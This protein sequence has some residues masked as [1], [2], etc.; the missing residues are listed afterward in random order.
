V[1]V[2]RLWQRLFGTGIVASLDDWETAEPTDPDLLEWLARELVA[3]DYSLEHVARLILTSRAYAAVRPPRR[4]TAEQ[5]ADSVLAACGKPYDV[6]PMNIDIDGSR[7]TTL[8]LNLGTPTRAWQFAAL[9]NERDRPSL[10]L[11]FAQTAVTL[12]EAFG[13]RGERQNP[14]S[15]RESEPTPLQPAIL[16]NGVFLKRACQLSDSS[17]FTALATGDLPLDTFVDEVFLRILARPPEPAEREAARA[18][19]AEGYA[20]RLVANAPA[21]M[22]PERPVGV[23]WSNHLSDEANQA[24]LRLA[25]IAALGDTPTSRL[26]P[27]WRERAED[28]VWTLYNLTEFVFVP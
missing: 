18:L 10:S 12:L 24:K 25:E 6:E 22:A 3:H 1:I 15:L 2:N 23:T 28:L 4:M 21:A 17:G 27:D 9:G 13:W 11:P 14:V 7:T 20:E 8:S 19:V 26:A 16:A 5:V